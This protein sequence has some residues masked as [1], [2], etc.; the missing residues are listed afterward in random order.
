MRLLFA[1]LFGALIGWERQIKD[2]SAG[3]RTH[4]NIVKIDERK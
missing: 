2:K 3:L 1:S 4:I